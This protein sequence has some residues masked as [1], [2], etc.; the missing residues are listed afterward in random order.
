MKVD[1]GIYRR[2]KTWLLFLH[3]LAL[4]K[5]QS[6]INIHTWTKGRPYHSHS[7]TWDSSCHSC[8]TEA[9]GSLMRPHSCQPYTF[10][11]GVMH[12]LPTSP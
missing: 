4:G 8:E 12:P 7:L 3:I 10:A 5:D 9:L 2:R 1:S 11:Q 6:F